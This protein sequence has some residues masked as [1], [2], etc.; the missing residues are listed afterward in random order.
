M[1]PEVFPNGNE[2]YTYRSWF[3]D[4]E[5]IENLVN[6]LEAKTVDDETGEQRWKYSFGH[7]YRW[8]FPYPNEDAVPP[9]TRAP[10]P[11]Q[12]AFELAIRNLS[13]GTMQFGPQTPDELR[14]RFGFAASERF[15]RTTRE[16]PHVD[17]WNTAERILAT[18]LL[19]YCSLT[20]KDAVYILGRAGIQTTRVALSSAVNAWKR[21]KQFPYNIEKPFGEDSHR[22]QFFVKVLETKTGLT[23]DELR[24]LAFEDIAPNNL[25]RFDAF[26]KTYQTLKK[27]PQ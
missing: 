17:E 5:Q 22:M 1:S 11:A 7:M 16:A 12:S 24:E 27:E 9:Y 19:N 18:G 6:L 10:V 15:K 26:I 8:L 4:P 3:H 14:E 20:F 2:A 23:L 25:H 13:N 21:E